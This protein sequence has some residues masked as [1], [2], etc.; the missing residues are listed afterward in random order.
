MLYLTY[1]D[2]GKCMHINY[3]LLIRIGNNAFL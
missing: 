3:K 1:V 2:K